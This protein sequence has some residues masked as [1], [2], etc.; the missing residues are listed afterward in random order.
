MVIL[1]F[2]FNNLQSNV[3]ILEF[4][5]ASLVA[6]ITT[7]YMVLEVVIKLQFIVSLVTSLQLVYRVLFGSILTAALSIGGMYSVDEFSYCK[8]G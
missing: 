2:S 4:D 3:T 7:V 1:R 5:P 6:L 8:K